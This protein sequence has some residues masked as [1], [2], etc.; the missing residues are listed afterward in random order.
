MK[1]MMRVFDDMP[2]PWPESVVKLVDAL[3]EYIRSEED[4]DFE[5]ALGVLEVT[6]SEEEQ[7]KRNTHMQSVRLLLKELEGYEVGGLPE[8]KA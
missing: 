8:K 6:L 2:D 5:V 4:L 1:S 7:R 3:R